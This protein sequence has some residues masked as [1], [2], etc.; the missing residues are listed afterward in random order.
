MRSNLPDYCSRSRSLVLM[1]YVGHDTTGITMFH[2]AWGGRELDIQSIVLPKVPLFLLNENDDAL[3]P[4][5]VDEVDYPGFATHSDHFDRKWITNQH[6]KRIK[7][8]MKLV[9]PS[10]ILPHLKQVPIRSRYVRQDRTAR[11]QE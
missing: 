6:Y 8:G 5:S 4:D 9:D 3:L 7:S 10:E 1:G 11:S 2:N